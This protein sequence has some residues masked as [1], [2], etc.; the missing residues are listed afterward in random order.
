MDVDW[1]IGIM[2]DD[3]VTFGEFVTPS[4]ELCED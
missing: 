2:K 3:A 1:N 4:K